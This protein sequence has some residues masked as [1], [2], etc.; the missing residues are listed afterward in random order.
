MIEARGLSRDYPSGRRTLC[1]LDDVSF[2]VGRGEFVSITGPSGSGKSTLLG[3]LAGL[4]RP[5]RGRVLALGR[6]LTEMSEDELSIFRGRHIG[7]VF[8]SFQLI[9]T[10]TAIENVRVPAELRGDASLGAR[11]KEL[12][13]QMGLGE[14]LNHYPSQ[15]SG[16]ELQRVAIAR[17][18]LVRPEIVLA[19]EPTGNLDS[20]SG[21]RVMDI[22]SSLEGDATLILVTHDRELAARAG[23]EIR[24]RDGRIE[25]VVDR[26]GARDERRPAAGDGA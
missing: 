12:L 21:A 17:A 20:A 11:A 5:S 1:V 25:E 9:P 16:G 15:L 8:Q 2:A 13:A 14:R 23:R 24:L 26:R 19:D 3:L 10:L 7:F 18:M 4:D 22:L 6:D